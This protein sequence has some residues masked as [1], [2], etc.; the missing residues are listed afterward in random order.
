M[1]LTFFY[2]PPVQNIPFAAGIDRYLPF[3]EELGRWST[4]T[5]IRQGV[6]FSPCC[7]DGEYVLFVGDVNTV[8]DKT[9]IV[10]LEVPAFDALAL[11][12][13]HRF[14]ALIDSLRF[15]E[16]IHRRQDGG[17]YGLRLLA[18]QLNIPTAKLPSLN[19]KHYALLLPSPQELPYLFV[20]YLTCYGRR[21]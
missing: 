17:F 9:N 15:S 11:L 10:P 3:V 20:K 12:E 18:D 21:P 2:T 5:S 7:D 13:K 1:K 16:W 19:S 14:P 4:I 6:K 8:E